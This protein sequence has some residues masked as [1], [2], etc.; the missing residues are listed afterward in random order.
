MESADVEIHLGS[1]DMFGEILLLMV[2]SKDGWWFPT[3]KWKRG[4]DW[5]D[6]ASKKIFELTG[7]SV[8]K[9]QFKDDSLMYYMCGIIDVFA[10]VNIYDN[11]MRDNSE[12]KVRWVPAQ[13]IDEKF[14]KRLQNGFVEMTKNVFGGCCDENE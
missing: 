10:N 7:I 13:V 6:M 9:K 2:P 3:I 11:P 1:R 12:K 8:P 5:A 14:K 4:D